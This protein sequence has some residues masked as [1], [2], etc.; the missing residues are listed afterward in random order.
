VLKI[1]MSL[2]RIMLALASLGAVFS[3]AGIVFNWKFS[4]LRLEVKV[5][6]WV[7]VRVVGV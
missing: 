6:I 1:N 7:K 5:R 3:V 4:A 2:F